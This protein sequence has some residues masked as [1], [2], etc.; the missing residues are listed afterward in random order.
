MHEMVPAAFLSLKVSD[1]LNTE[2]AQ[3]MKMKPNDWNSMSKTSVWKRS[4]FHP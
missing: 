3:K 1:T 4:T 2:A